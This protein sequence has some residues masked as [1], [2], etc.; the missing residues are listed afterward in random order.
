MRLLSTFRAIS[1][2]FS[3]KALNS[4]LGDSAS[5][6]GPLAHG[7]GRKCILLLGKIPE[8]MRKRAMG[9]FST[10]GRRDLTMQNFS[11]SFRLRP[12]PDTTV[13]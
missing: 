8:T 3:S 2:I 13:G 11:G 4:E 5:G 9:S 6:P 10:E 7:P 1:G 12:C